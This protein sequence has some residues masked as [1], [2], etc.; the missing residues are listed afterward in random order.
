MST[1]LLERPATL[2][3]NVFERERAPSTTE[4]CRSDRTDGHAGPTLGGLIAGVWEGLAMD[5]TV[6]CPVCHGTMTSRAPTRAGELHG[7]CGDCGAQL[8]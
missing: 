4:P 6:P 8:S 7:A 5:R 2:F 3:D 1:L